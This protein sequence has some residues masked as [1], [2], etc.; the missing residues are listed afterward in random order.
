MDRRSFTKL[1]ALLPFSSATLKAED[2]DYKLE[3]PEEPLDHIKFEE[4]KEHKKIAKPIIDEKDSIIQLGSVVAYDPSTQKI[5][6]YKGYPQIP[7]GTYL[8]KGDV[9]LG[10]NNGA[11]IHFNK[12]DD[13][14]T[15]LEME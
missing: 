4:P 15:T 14:D 11:I 13:T 12:T 10:Q 3:E 2:G 6:L 5:K 1:L 8:G 7:L 9:S